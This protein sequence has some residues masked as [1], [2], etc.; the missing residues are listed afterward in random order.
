M[1]INEKLL[2]QIIEDV[3]CDMK[4]SDKFVLFNVFVV[5]IVLQIVVFVG[6][7]FLIEVGEVCQGIQ[8]DEVIIV[9]GLVF[10]LV[11]IVNIVGLL[12]KSILCEVI[13]G[14]E[15]EGIRV[16][17]ICCFKFFDV[18]FVVVEGNCLSG[19]GIFIGI[20]LKGIMVIYQQ[21]LLLFFNLELF[22]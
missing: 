9:V 20:Q 10:G 4:G 3:F 5:F 7:G 15:E 21:G 17:V 6:D 12:Y 11:Q 14:I 19:F 16:C 2:C 13:V 1:E 8:Q 18:V 22:L